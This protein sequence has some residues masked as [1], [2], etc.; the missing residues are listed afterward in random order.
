MAPVKAPQSQAKLL[1]SL[2]Q[3]PEAYRIKLTNHAE[4]LK[5]SGN[6]KSMNTCILT[7]LDE[8]LSLNIELQEKPVLP[9]PPLRA[10]T[11]RMTAET[12]ERLTMAAANWQL[13]TAL[14][15]SMNAVLNT[16]LRVYLKKHS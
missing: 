11:V 1:V 14:P 4:Q 7:A 8:Y 16:A 15:T 6:K 10:F 13:K 5:S 2:F 3:I 12:K 9:S